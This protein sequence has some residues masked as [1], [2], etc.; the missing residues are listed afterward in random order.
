MPCC[1]I[2]HF[3]NLTNLICLWFIFLSLADAVP[4]VSVVSYTK[5]GLVVL[6]FVPAVITHEDL[7]GFRISV[8]EIDPITNGTRST[9]S[10]RVG[11]LVRA[12]HVS[13]A[14]NPG[15][16]RIEIIPLIGL[17]SSPAGVVVDTLGM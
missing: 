5:Y 9:H 12:F 11:P 17:G 6:W 4:A 15:M 2:H 16:Y 10:F 8:A 1:R 14:K 13:T 3:T 7:R